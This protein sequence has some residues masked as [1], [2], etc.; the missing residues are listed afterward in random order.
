MS[1]STSEQVEES[2]YPVGGI[3]VQIRKHKNMSAEI[4]TLEEESGLRV[5]CFNV[6]SG[7]R[8]SKGG[9]RQS[10]C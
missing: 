2:K 3:D 6:I 4:E 8:L 1:V 9:S 10:Q 5:I 7:S